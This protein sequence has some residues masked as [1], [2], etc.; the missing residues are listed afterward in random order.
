VP[1]LPEVE[2]V[3]RQLVPAMVGERIEAVVL[4]RP[5]LRGPFPDGFVERLVGHTVLELHRRAKYLLADLS[6]RETLVMHLGMSGDFRVERR[7]ALPPLDAHDHVLIHLGS[8]AVVVFNDPRRFGS[9]ALVA[10]DQLAEHPAIATL[11]PEPLSASFTGAVLARACRGRTTPIKVALLDQRIVAGI[12]NIYAA[13]ALHRARLSPLRR[14][15]VIATPT[16]A[17]RDAAVRL[18]AAIKQVLTEAIARASDASYR[19]GRFRVYDREGKP[20][21][22]PSCGGTIRRRTQA[23]RATFYCPVCQR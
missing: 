17:P 19:G 11:G 16:G 20:C 22:R 5:N 9:M 4:R 8:G 3:R 23:G 18:V 7:D 6:S 15:S 21:R 1:E 14:A 10:T 12:G 2:T 13:E